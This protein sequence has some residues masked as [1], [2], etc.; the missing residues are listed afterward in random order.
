[1]CVYIYKEN[2]YFFIFYLVFWATQTRNIGFD[3]I[4][5]HD[6][7]CNNVWFFFHCLSKV[8]VKVC[9]TLAFKPLI[10]ADSLRWFI[11]SLL[12]INGQIRA[13][14][15]SKAKA[16]LPNYGFSC[17]HSFKNIVHINFREKCLFL[18]MGE[19]QFIPR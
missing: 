1:M 6:E 15:P 12:K 11:K 18:W 9:D 8:I 7:S 16:V 4:T 19:K 3:L 13:S 10:V 14:S 5:S 2:V 17:L